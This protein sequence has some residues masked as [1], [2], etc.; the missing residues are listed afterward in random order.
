M[1]KEQ[2]FS[3]SKLATIMELLHNQLSGAAPL[4]TVAAPH[5]STSASVRW[6]KV[7]APQ[8]HGQQIF[9]FSVDNV[10]FMGGQRVN[11]NLVG[12]MDL[13][14]L[15]VAR[16]CK[17]MD[18]MID[19]W[20]GNPLLRQKVGKLL[21]SNSYIP[22]QFGKRMEGEKLIYYKPS[23]LSNESSLDW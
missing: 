11:L 1:I 7:P 13:S 15:N 14:V 10:V 2:T 20:I 19:Y 21:A 5:G 18:K 23:L 22:T 16:M 12:N 9:Y 17:T 3:L 4:T 6:T 8:V